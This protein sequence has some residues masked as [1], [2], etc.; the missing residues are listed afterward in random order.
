MSSGLIDQLGCPVL[1]WESQD[2]HCLLTN[3][4]E[5]PCSVKDLIWL[6]KGD[7]PAAWWFARASYDAPLRFMPGTRFD[8]SNTNYWLAAH[9]VE[10]VTEMSFKQYLEQH[11]LQPAGLTSTIYD[12][13]VGLSG[14]QKDTLP[15]S[16]YLVEFAE[17]QGSQ[18]GT[19][20]HAR[21]ARA[22]SLSGELSAGIGC[23]SL[24]A[25]TSDIIKWY[26]LLFTEPEKLNLTSSAISRLVQPITHIYGDL[27]YGQGFHVVRS[28]DS[29]MP[30]GIDMAYHGGAIWGYKNFAAMRMAKTGP[31]DATIAAIFSNRK[32]NFEQTF[33]RDICR[34]AHDNLA[35]NVPCNPYPLMFLDNLGEIALGI[36]GTELAERAF[37]PAELLEDIMS[38]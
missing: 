4:S 35:L 7:V 34:V 37:P 5:Q 16:G 11:V 14:I 20:Q 32:L 38:S 31:G 27:Y 26:Q 2:G 33:E 10:A 24:Q 30:F 8:Y 29:S 12:T 23:S 19:Y 28:N 9:I 36:D 17:T 1:P 21:T 18:P 25:T 22:L 15:G 13:S 3:K 6:A